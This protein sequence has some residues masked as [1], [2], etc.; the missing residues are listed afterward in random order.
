MFSSRTLPVSEPGRTGAISQ[1]WRVTFAGLFF[2]HKK[3]PLDRKSIRRKPFSG[4]L[5]IRHRQSNH[6]TLET[7]SVF[8]LLLNIILHYV[9]LRRSD[10]ASPTSAQ[11][12]ESLESRQTMGPKWA[13]LPLALAR[14]THY[15]LGHRNTIYIFLWDLFFFSGR[16]T[17]SNIRT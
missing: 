8:C 16:K 15:R 7:E 5:L 1:R 3:W 11:Q 9:L 13:A 6:E 17:H 2:R 10:S 4:V 12:E 14:H